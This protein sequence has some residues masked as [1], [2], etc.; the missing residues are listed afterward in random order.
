MKETGGGG[1]VGG[2]GE[3]GK[4]LNLQY[5]LILFYSILFFFILLYP[6]TLEG[7]RGTKDEFA[8]IPFHL[9]LFSATLVHS[10][11][12]FDIFFP[13]ELKPVW[14]DN[15]IS[16]GSKEADALPCRFHISVC[17]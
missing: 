12:L 13:L 8:T 10:R 16:L 6:I 14:R 11:P 3:D 2:A 15:D 5:Q 1:W 7:R 4:S 9:V 17:L